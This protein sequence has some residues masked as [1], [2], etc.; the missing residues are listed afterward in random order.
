MKELTL[1]QKKFCLEY[2][3]TGNATQSA[4]KAGYSKKTACSIGSENLL[5]PEIQEYIK[6]QTEKTEDK[7]IMDISERQIFLTKII[8]GEVKDGDL[9][10]KLAD[11]LKAID[12]LNKMQG[13][14]LERVKVEDVM[15]TWF[16][17]T[18][19]EEKEDEEENVQ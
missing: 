12:I 2:M 4:L 6:I 7:S 18:G 14:Y 15:P 8:I 16:I 3:K 1:K 5:K 9:P 17:G 19:K 10:A 13:A 11:K